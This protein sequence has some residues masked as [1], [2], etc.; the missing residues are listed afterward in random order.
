MV[1]NI[2]EIINV[3]SKWWLNL[4]VSINVDL[5]YATQ[6]LHFLPV[7]KQRRY[8]AH[9]QT[10]IRKI[11]NNINDPVTTN[12][13]SYEYEASTPNGKFFSEQLFVNLSITNVMVCVRT[14][15]RSRKWSPVHK[16]HGQWTAPII[17][18][19]GVQMVRDPPEIERSLC[20]RAY[21]EFD[22]DYSYHMVHHLFFS[23]TH[24]RKP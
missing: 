5:L 24:S 13:N 21:T 11:F 3:D 4:F 14:Q 16:K 6:V 19:I 20:Y 9:K 15:R 17:L 23:G 18:S 1:S 10:R 22:I 8:F 12:S 2:R 7:R